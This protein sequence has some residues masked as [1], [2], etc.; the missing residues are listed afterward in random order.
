VHAGVM[1]EKPLDS[2]FGIIHF[3]KS[4]YQVGIRLEI[5]GILIGSRIPRLLCR[6]LIPLFA[7]QLATAATGTF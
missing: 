1:P 6:Q 3:L 7:G 5:R 4:H 2:R